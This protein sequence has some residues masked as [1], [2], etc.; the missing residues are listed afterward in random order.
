MNEKQHIVNGA[1]AVVDATGRLLSKGA[2]L[3]VIFCLFLAGYLVAL[4][5]RAA[6]DVPFKD[7]FLFAEIYSALA[8]HRL[9]A[10]GEILSAHNGHPYAALKLLI[11]GTLWA[12]LPWSWLM[13]GQVPLLLVGAFIAHAQAKKY[14]NPAIAGLLAALVLISPRQWENLYWAMQISSAIST[15]AG[16][17]AFYLAARYQEERKFA[18]LAGSLGLGLLASISMAAGFAAFAIVVA[19]LLVLRPPRRESWI[20]VSV[21]ILGLGLYIAAM[22]MEYRVGVGGS[23]VSSILAVKHLLLMMSN[24]IAFF[25]QEEKFIAFSIGCLIVLLVAHSLWLGIRM[26]PTAVFELSCLAWGTGLIFAVTYSRLLMGIFQPDAPRYVPLVAP[27]IIGSGL[28]LQRAG[29]RCLLYTMAVALALGWLQSAESEW[30][31]TPYRR[32]NLMRALE[33]LCAGRVLDNRISLNEDEIRDVQRFFCNG[34][35]ARNTRG[36]P[37]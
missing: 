11:M 19:V 17:G 37:D 22:M 10:L 36:G 1:N 14:G 25:G 31:I 12:G 6:V 32:E 30:R 9:P 29:K 34:D 16:L 20:V 24:G 21:G 33:S 28:I 15:A 3:F 18:Q 2:L 27:L 7:E 4:I 13:Y 5:T 8:D 26:L 35:A 23:D